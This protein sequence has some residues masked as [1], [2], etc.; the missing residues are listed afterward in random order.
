MAPPNA[1]AQARDPSVAGFVA[2]RSLADFN[3]R[4]HAHALPGP[5]TPEEHKRLVEQFDRA[6][7]IRALTS[8]HNRARNS[9]GARAFLLRS[10]NQVRQAPT[11]AAPAPFAEPK[12]LGEFN[13]QLEATRLH[14][15]LAVAEMDVLLQQVGRTDL[16]AALRDVHQGG[17]ARAEAETM[18][19]RVLADAVVRAARGQLRPSA[20]SELPPISDD[21]DGFAGTDAPARAP[22]PPA[23]PAERPQHRPPAPAAR[24]STPSPQTADA[25]HD[26]PQ[27]RAYGKRAALCV[28]PSD[29]GSQG[30]TLMV[31]MAAAVPD[32][33]KTYDWKHS[34]IRFQLMRKELLYLLA[35]LYGWAGAA[36]FK[37]HGESKV[38]SLSLENQDGGKL[39][40]KMSDKGAP[41]LV[42]PVTEVDALADFTVLALQQACKTFHQFGPTELLAFVRQRVAPGM[43]AP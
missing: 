6:D 22:A 39:F 3:E 1:H 25:N 28:E 30:P 13:A 27:A 9:D 41:M 18:L 42:L 32:K 5:L 24:A 38:K 23:A 19:R 10:I 12:N 35:V 37:N 34:K 14:R 15:P 21:D 2:P 33:E 8:L 11:A 20:A 17:P 4:L 26:R 40:M 36:E 7:V 29:S 43:R 16:I 31:E